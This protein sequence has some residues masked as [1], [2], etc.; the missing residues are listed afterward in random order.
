MRTFTRFALYWI[1]TAPLAWAGLDF[2]S[3]DSVDADSQQPY[4]IDVPADA[5]G[6]RIVLQAEGL[7]LELWE[8]AD[9]SGSADYSGQIY[10]GTSTIIVDGEDLTEGVWTIGI[11][12][13]GVEPVDYTLTGEEMPA[14]RTLDW[15]AG[16]GANAYSVGSESTGGVYYFEVE[17]QSAALGLW[18]QALNIQSGEARLL[19]RESSSQLASPSNHDYD[20]E[21]TDVG[22]GVVRTDA[23]EGDLWQ[24]TV[25][26]EA[27][28]EWSLVA[29]DV[30]VTDLG[31]LA[32]S[33]SDAS[34]ADTQIKGEGVRFFRTSIPQ[35]ALGWHLWLKPE[36]GSSDTWVAEMRVRETGEGALPTP[37][38]NNNWD[39][40]SGAEYDFAFEGQ[41]LMVP[42]AGSSWEDPLFEPGDSAF[43]VAVVGNPGDSFY[44]DSRQQAVESISFD[45][46][47]DELGGDGSWFYSF[48][49]HIPSELTGWEV[50]AL[51]EQGNAFVAARQSQL[52]NADNN[53]AFSEVEGADNSFTIIA[54]SLSGG[55]SFVTVYGDQESV[56]FR[57]QNREPLITEIDFEDTVTND[58][59][60]R[61]G[62]R[63]YRISDINSQ[64]FNWLLELDN[65]APDSEIAIRRN[66]IPGYRESRSNGNESSH[67]ENDSSSDLGF[68]QRP[69]H[70]PDIWYI[71][72][73]NPD[74]ALGEFTLESGPIVPIP[75]SLDGTVSDQEIQTGEWVFYE[76]VIP[77]NLEFEGEAIEGWEL[78]LN[79]PNG[80]VMNMVLQRGQMP[81]G[82]FNA[83]GSIGR[84]ESWS[85]SQRQ[86]ASSNWV[87][88]V[89][90]AD[91]SREILH[92][93]GMGQPLQAG[94]YYL[95]VANGNFADPAEFNLH[96]RLI[97][98]DGSGLYY[99]IK[100][101]AFDDSG[102]QSS[103]AEGTLDP[104]GVSYYAV[105]IPEN[106]SSWRVT[107]ELP[108]DHE[109][110]LFLRKDFLP[111]SAIAFNSN[112]S[113]A[114]QNIYDPLGNPS[115]NAF[116][117]QVRLDTDGRESFDL[118]PASG[119]EYVEPGRYYIMVA[120]EGQ[121]PSGNNES[122][123]EPIDYTVISHGEIPVQNLGMIDSGELEE[124][125][126]ES[127]AFGE[128]N[129]YR[130]ELPEGELGIRIALENVEEGNPVLRLRDGEMPANLYNHAE[131][132]GGLNL[133]YGHYNP[134]S[135]R[136]WDENILYLTNPEG[137]PY[138]LTV[139][140]RLPL[141][142][143][144]YDLAFEGI[145]APAIDID[146]PTP[147]TIEG[148]QPGE[149]VFYE[150]DVPEDVLGWEVNLLEWVGS[151]N[152][153][154]RPAIALRPELLPRD[155]S[156]TG[157]SG[158]VQPRDRTAPI[159][160][161]HRTLAK[162]SGEW[163]GLHRSPDDGLQ[164][165]TYL[166]SIPMGQPMSPGVHYVGFH[167]PGSSDEPLDITWTNRAIGPE[168]EDFSHPVRDLEFDGSSTG[169]LEPRELAYYQVEIPEDTYQ[170]WH[171]ELLL[172]EH[173]SRGDEAL[174][175]VRKDYI[176]NT[177][178]NSSSS[179]DLSTPTSGNH[180]QLR[181]DL[182]GEES[183]VLWPKSGEDYIPGGTYYLMVASQG[184]SPDK[185]FNRIGVGEI[186]Y[187]LVS[188]GEYE[189]PAGNLLGELSPGDA[190]SIS[191]AY[192]K[193]KVS[194]YQF[195]IPELVEAIELRMNVLNGDPIMRL[196][197][198]IFP[199]SIP[200]NQYGHYSGHGS[201]GV[202]TSL[203]TRTDSSSTPLAGVYT[204]MVIHDGTSDF[205]AAEYEI[206][207]E[208][209]GPTVIEDIDGFAD[210]DVTIDG[211]E[212]AYYRVT[213]PE[214]IDG[215]DL[216]AW[217]LSITDWEGPEPPVMVISKDEFP[218]SVSATG[219]G[220]KNRSGFVTD[221]DSG[222]RLVVR[223]NH[224]RDWT[225]RTESA[226]GDE[227]E[228]IT[229]SLPLGQP[230]QAGEYYIGF[231]SAQASSDPITF[232]W[233]S[234]AIGL[235]GSGMTHEVAELSMDG[236]VSGSLAPR[237]VAH[238]YVDI[239]ANT[240]HWQM[241][242]DLDE[243]H[244]AIA[245][246]RGTYLPL[247]QAQATSHN[248]P[249]RWS[250]SETL[251]GT[252]LTAPH[253]RLNQEGNQSFAIWPDNGEDSIEAGR[254]YI[255]VVG[256]GQDPVESNRVG[257]GE[258]NYT[259]NNGPIEIHDLGDAI[260]FGDSV[261]VEGE[262]YEA[263]RYN[264]YRFEIADDNE[265]IEIRLANR[266]GDPY[267]YINSGINAPR[268]R[269]GGSGAYLRNHFSDH[270]PVYN[271]Q[272]FV[273]LTDMEPGVYTMAVGDG[274]NSI[275]GDG[276]YELQIN[277][278]APV[279][280]PFTA[281]TFPVSGSLI[282][283]QSD[284]YRV[285]VSD[286]LEL[287]TGDLDEEEVTVLGWKVSITE[288]SG[289]T[290][291]R[292]RRG[293]LPEGSSAGSE[294]S[295]WSQGTQLIVPPLLETAEFYIEV[296]G[297]EATD[298]TLVSEPIVMDSLDYVW[299][300]PA[301]GSVPDESRFGNSQSD[302]SSDGMEL[303]AGEFH[304]YAI[305]VPEDNGALLRTVLEKISGD[306]LGL[307]LH[308][309]TLPTTSHSESSGFGSIRVHSMS[310]SATTQYGNWV[311]E[312]LVETDRMEPGIW[313][314]KVQAEGASANYHLRL[315]HNAADLVQDLA[316]EGGSIEGQ[317]LLAT[318]WRY[319]RVE[320]PENPED[321]PAEWNITFSD[322]AENVVMYI[323]DTIPPGLWS[324]TNMSTSTAYFNPRD[325]TRDGFWSQNRQGPENR[326]FTSPGTYTLTGEMLRPGKTYYL[327]FRADSASTFAVSSDI[328]EDTIGSMYGVF[329]SI[330][331]TG[332]WLEED[333]EPG[334]VKTWAVEFPA[335]AQRW[336]SIAENNPE[337]EFYVGHHGL[338]PDF[339]GDWNF[340]ESES[341]ADW[342]A[343]RNFF[344]SYR[345]FENTF[346]L[347]AVNTGSATES[348]TMFIDW[349][350]EDSFNH[351]ISIVGEG[352]VAIEPEDYVAG[353][354]VELTAIEDVGWMF[355][356][357]TGDEESTDNPLTVTSFEELDITA[358][359]VPFE[360]VF[361]QSAE[362]ITEELLLSYSWGEEVEIE[363]TIPNT[364]DSSASIVPEVM[365]DD[366]STTWT[367]EFDPIEVPGGETETV[368]LTY[369]MESVMPSGSGD[370]DVWVNEIHAGSFLGIYLEAYLYY[371][372]DDYELEIG[373]TE[374]VEYRLH[375]P[376]DE[377]IEMDIYF[378][379]DGV[380]FDRHEAVSASAGFNSGWDYFEWI[381]DEAGEFEVMVNTVHALGSPA[382]VIDPD[383][384]PPGE[385]DVEIA[386]ISAPT[387]AIVG[388]PVSIR[389]TVEET[390]GSY[391]GTIELVLSLDGDAVD[392]QTVSV[393]AGETTMHA[394]SYIFDASGT[395]N[396]SVNDETFVIE[397]E[398]AEVDVE[399]NNLQVSST[400]LHNGSYLEV[401][402]NVENLD[403]IPGEA[404]VRFI[405]NDLIG[406]PLADPPV[407]IHTETARIPMDSEESQTVIFYYEFFGPGEYS[408]AI[409]DLAPVE[410]TVLPGWSQFGYGHHNQQV[411]SFGAPQ[412][413]V[414]ARWEFEADDQ[415]FAYIR[416]E[417]IVVGDVVYFG[418]YP[419]A[420]FA[421]DV[422]S[423]D[424]VWGS[425]FE[426]DGMVDKSPAYS[427]GRVFVT[428]AGSD[429]TS[430]HAIN[431]ET[432]A[433]LWTEADLGSSSLTAPIVVGN[434]VYVG[435]DDGYLDA[436]DAEDGSLLWSFEAG[437]AVHSTPAF[438]DG[439]IYVGSDDGVFAVDALSG[440]AIW[441]ED[442]S[443]IRAPIAFG[444][445]F[446]DGSPRSQLYLAGMDGM[447]T[448]LDAETG[449]FL[450][451]YDTGAMIHGSPAVISNEVYVANNDGKVYKLAVADGAMEW[452]FAFEADGAIIG[453]PVYANSRIH[454]ATTE[455]TVY[456]VPGFI[457]E[458]AALWTYDLGGAV[459]SSMVMYD[460]AIFV[461]DDDARFHALQGG[462]EGPVPG[463]APEITED[464]IAV[465]FAIGGEGI[466]G[467]EFDGSGDGL[468]IEWFQ[469]GDL[470]EGDRYN[471]EISG[472]LVVSD[473]T[474][475]DV[476]DYSVTI[477]N[478]YGE[479]T[480]GP[481]SVEVYSR[482]AIELTMADDLYSDPA[483]NE[484]TLRIFAEEEGTVDLETATLEFMGGRSSGDG[485]EDDLVFGLY[486][487]DGNSVLVA[488]GGMFPADDGTISIPKDGEVLLDV[489]LNFADADE[490]ELWFFLSEAVEL[491]ENDIIPFALGAPEMFTF[492]VQDTSEAPRSTYSMATQYPDVIL[493]GTQETMSVTIA[494]IDEGLMG[495]EATWIRI[496]ADGPGDVTFTLPDDAF[497]GD[498][499]VI[500]NSGDYGPESGYELA[501][502]YNEVLNWEV[503]F[504]SVGE[505]T[506]TLE[507]IADVDGT[508]VVLAEA[509]DS[510]SIG[511]VPAITT[512]PE[513]DTQTVLHG[514]S[515]SYSAAASGYGEL[516]YQWS[517]DGQSVSDWSTDSDL[518]IPQATKRHEGNYTVAVR[519]PFGEDESDSVELIVELPE[520]L[521]DAVGD[522]EVADVDE[523]TGTTSYNSDWLG[524]FY[525]LEGS[526]GWIYT[527]RIGW[528]YVW[529]GQATGTMWFWDPL[530]DLVFYTDEEIHPFVYSETIG[531]AV[532]ARG[533][534]NK[535]YLHVL[536][537]DEIIDLDLE[538]GEPDL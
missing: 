5:D 54:D 443:F 535:R 70:P 466:I 148:I 347:T 532:Y 10:A 189:I 229:I 307:Y 112:T 423:G 214:K 390:G 288:A 15:D 13:S 180:Q 383:G 330:E 287:R 233:N 12:N 86:N 172:P 145:E 162:R 485:D 115:F 68:L 368:I 207:L 239:P 507:L 457:D 236:S 538:G 24:L 462:E 431:A 301:H 203:I 187:E 130:F 404:D 459:R 468:E 320:M 336:R 455:G 120:S 146:N 536:S 99:E 513:P 474:I 272:Q 353:D 475:E 106:K 48:N 367:V 255:S 246:I 129:Y 335:E 321:M 133:F 388:E 517:R 416:G 508:E 159:W 251:S 398:A 3:T 484:G 284:F 230:L 35:E 483:L 206:T 137:G 55:S 467:L 257:T 348:F 463:E 179:F 211:G 533:A 53:Q 126:G 505:Y 403:S 124:L 19:L 514:S 196:S 372:Y 488:G 362:L 227:Y 337:L 39:T 373:D 326:R 537:D 419:G 351:N 332:A 140:A 355:S 309:H 252:S 429:S 333:L 156:N 188:H 305:E 345:E 20:S 42:E 315:D 471:F 289:E 295:N 278:I 56:S 522:A 117:R 525:T 396:G 14:V 359:F 152:T 283:D 114:T 237:E 100:D 380:E 496:E 420:V 138:H 427:N 316:L 109:A 303:D 354:T 304:L 440:E 430:L 370:F 215:W 135:Y 41:G 204:L 113:N 389:V 64:A 202:S 200:V 369:N 489:S 249:A 318:D 445:H 324:N 277:S 526:I 105:D 173:E 405:V 476:G 149:W 218:S 302:I 374:W 434:T 527:Q 298:Y 497:G 428:T 93:Y 1:L 125:I 401:T 293:D 253:V 184:Q 452:S 498:S 413:S 371:S 69:D 379:V 107:L 392:S 158:N 222:D 91:G 165:R 60:D 271:W 446:I 191:G 29:G 52:P 291:F 382:T 80:Q 88:R 331:G 85:T 28:A 364:S 33:D 308:P 25:I 381:V 195:E 502:D 240:P 328:G 21:M 451:E 141:S 314:V 27:G 67:E 223:G 311:P 447:L 453:S 297:V 45:S 350:D 98:S 116:G 460:E 216:L 477:R 424:P 265:V 95:A 51:A 290:R 356:A 22:G 208:D 72:V 178:S 259:L 386:N 422:D 480:S 274:L 160:N 357:W 132:T 261:S 205:E 82:T 473:V 426:P 448:A 97:G 71:G 177:E 221:W 408:V 499:I 201:V 520:A 516:E 102:D 493:A 521:P 194:Y 231:R 363:V 136:W 506:V 143:S 58:E 92:S 34:S 300:M 377:D 518:T 197:R 417:A 77:E 62:W 313:F 342:E 461:G 262:T 366:G 528:A 43:Y 238:Y 245:Y 57:L 268:L 119:E 175:L 329:A 393:S 63:Y 286:T 495:Y 192:G 32:A 322:P 226:D 169:T 44:F 7:S 402:A 81:T 213:V 449:D 418:S 23:G 437:A 37:G 232:S 89:N 530:A 18:R 269:L 244:Q 275:D 75:L 110:N 65:Q 49:L 17:T 410:V 444:Q 147:M 228:R 317:N 103:V 181:L 267:F 490:Y 503:G 492:T 361:V 534:G 242:L 166:H 209:T 501:V 16:D 365:F 512:Q 31:D 435:S 26:A 515:V 153:N 104:L 319:Y 469:D 454:F 134:V 414:Q 442:Y 83:F 504:S 263:G 456:A 406:G 358:E 399:F 415:S 394:F 281:G 481:I 186:D 250:T 155:T 66:N 436:F 264:F 523:D 285:D 294:Q 254:Y 482:Y 40:L 30:E 465:G 220:T 157:W 282:Q 144:T 131:S 170:S 391:D 225:W 224:R 441:S 2:T 256:I 183:F 511:D 47:T 387:E 247:N 210:S 248:N 235:E 292:I 509:E 76:F 182:D 279:N 217:E 343:Q 400:E 479:V 219:S 340:L 78:R 6:W 94:T 198:G 529:S 524:V 122:G 500:E 142:E 280:I 171:F 472:G 167:N 127:Y 438:S 108:E 176:P 151:S 487:G 79:V 74:S 90:K 344:S 174:L 168:A 36:V 338:L 491:S 409:G 11:E 118:W 432:G 470:L 425:P 478:D 325:W 150:V 494:P 193:G 296:Q 276:G 510:L 185:G 8:G 46:I 101:L 199:G 531:F 411:G 334:E 378:T 375:A 84:A 128:I 421:L 349:R 339:D 486:N 59:P 241:T 154:D 385:G 395:Y 38:W 519:S 312:T 323:R 4:A 458:P 61:T 439:V 346:Y 270:F 450:W 234:T 412:F 73:Y 306:E 260:A 397:V 407:E 161:S 139:G 360:G 87:G 243:G 384:M 310:G 376:A 190:M 50:T 352:S 433:E 111:N 327:G 164:F 273:T 266:V 464:L 341:E 9:T 121:N 299:E 123:A 212:W 258:V 163:T 96:S